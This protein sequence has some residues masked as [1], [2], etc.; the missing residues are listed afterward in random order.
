MSPRLDSLPVNES[1]SQGWAQYPRHECLTQ[2][3]FA[4]FASREAPSAATHCEGSLTSP[5]CVHLHQE[6]R[7]PP[8]IPDSTCLRSE[9]EIQ[10]SQTVILVTN[11]PVNATGTYLRS[12]SI[13]VPQVLPT[14][15]LASDRQFLQGSCSDVSVDEANDDAR[16]FGLVDGYV[17]VF[18]RAKSMIDQLGYKNQAQRR[19]LVGV[20]RPFILKFC[21]LFTRW[22]LG[23][24]KTA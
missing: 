15:R 10:P 17:C 8:S 19:K 20:G 12:S 11:G 3:V 18:R 1:H 9:C 13:S 23:R 7:H 4:L 2:N 22:Q 21:R 6:R 5:A 16:C 24:S 14:S